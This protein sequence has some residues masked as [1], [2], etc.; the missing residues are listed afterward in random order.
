LKNEFKPYLKLWT[1]LLHFDTETKLWNRLYIMG[2]L[3]PCEAMGPGYNNNGTQG[4]GPRRAEGSSTGPESPPGQAVP[5]D[6]E[7]ERAPQWL[8]RIMLAGSTGAQ[9][10]GYVLPNRDA[11]GPLKFGKDIFQTIGL[12]EFRLWFF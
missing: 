6:R 11:R 4:V 9:R 5:A 2:R 1:S 3:L 7:A 8:D 12:V 10:E